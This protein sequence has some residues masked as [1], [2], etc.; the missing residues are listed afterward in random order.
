MAKPLYHHRRKLSN[1]PVAGGGGGN[2]LSFSSGK[3]SY[4]DVFSGGLKPRSGG[5]VGAPGFSSRRVAVE[6]YAEIFGGKN[7]AHHRGSS[8]PV[9]DLSELDDG[10]NG[11]DVFRGSGKKMDYSMI[12]GGGDDG[13]EPS[14][15]PVPAFDELFNGVKR[16]K[17]NEVKTR[18]P[19]ENGSPLKGPDRLNVSHNMKSHSCDGPAPVLDGEKQ[20]NMSF[21]KTGERR[22]DILNGTTHIAQL[23]AVPGFTYVIDETARLRDTQ[24][25]KSMPPIP[26]EGNHHRSSSDHLQ[27]NKK[28]KAM[29]PVKV[30]VDTK[31]P[32]PDQSDEKF[33]RRTKWQIPTTKSSEF[34]VKHKVECNRRDDDCLKDNLLHSDD[35]GLDSHLPKEPSPSCSSANL[36]DSKGQVKQSYVSS[37]GSKSEGSEAISGCAT[38]DEELDVNSAA[39]ASVEALRKA[40]E[41]AQESIRIAKEKMERKSRP[42]D[43]LKANGGCEINHAQETNG[44]KENNVKETGKSPEMKVKDP[45]RS[46]H[47]SE[48]GNSGFV[49]GFTQK[50]KPAA[51]RQA[52]SENVEV[53]GDNGVAT[54][55]SQ[56]LNNGKQK[57][58]ALASELVVKKNQ[59]LQPGDKD[60]DNCEDIKPAKESLKVNAMDEVNSV[61]S[62]RQ[63]VSTDAKL[64]VLQ[65]SE[66]NESMV[67][68]GSSPNVNDVRPGDSPMSAKNDEVTT[69]RQHGLDREECNELKTDSFWETFTDMQ[70][71]LPKAWKDLP[72]SN[73]LEVEEKSIE[74]KAGNK[75]EIISVGDNSDGKIGEVESNLQQEELRLGLDTKE[76]AADKENDESKLA[77]DI[78]S[79]GKRPE[80]D[81]KEHLDG[82]NEQE[83]D[84]QRL[85]KSVEHEESQIFSEE[86]ELQ[87]EIERIPAEL[88]KN[89]EA[90]S[91]DEDAYNSSLDKNTNVNEELEESVEKSRVHLFEQV[92]HEQ[93]SDT[94]FDKY[95]ANGIENLV[96]FEDSSRSFMENNCEQTSERT[97]TVEEKEDRDEFTA[98]FS[99]QESGEDE[100]VVDN[101]G[102][103]EYMYELDGDAESEKA[104]EEASCVE[105]EHKLET[106]SVDHIDSEE[107]IMESTVHD[108]SDAPASGSSGS[109]L[110]FDFEHVVRESELEDIGT[111]SFSYNGIDR[112][113]IDNQNATE[114]SAV[115]D[116]SNS[117]L[118]DLNQQSEIHEID[119]Q[120][121][122]HITENL[123]E[124]VR[125]VGGRDQIESDIESESSLHHGFV[126]ESGGTVETGHMA[127]IHSEKEVEKDNTEKCPKEQQWVQN[128]KESEGSHF[129]GEEDI[130]T[131]SDGKTDQ[132]S[133]NYEEDFSRTFVKETKE[134]REPFQKEEA[135][136]DDIGTSEAKKRDRERE[137]DR[138]AV[139]RAIREARERAFAEARERAERAA[140]EK[141]TAEVRQRAMAEARGKLDKVSSSVKAPVDKASIAAKLRAERAA[142]ERA[143]SEARERA[144]EK[145]MSQ[146]TTGETKPQSERDA[147]GK[148]SGA[149]RDAGLKHSYSSSDLDN[150]DGNSSESAQRRKARLERH[151]R[152]MERA[153]KALAEK[154]LRDVL[155]Q[156]EQAQKN[157][158][159]E[160]LDAEI[161]RWASGKEGNLRALLSTLQ[162]I[163]GPASGWQPISLT[164]IVTTAAVKKAY[165]KATLYV[166]PDKLQQR[167]ASIR[168]KYICEKVF[169]LLKAAWNKFNS[170]ER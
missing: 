71:E 42:R 139:E 11:S 125:E 121:F 45:I 4:D 48:L 13:D 31:S 94:I 24:Q 64:N 82:G 154:N 150:F 126:H 43:S 124:T 107:N 104:A 100:C 81:L 57:M 60:M 8:I 102:T 135:G 29:P 25:N 123:E 66:L 115:N 18:V 158:L 155:A 152:I 47:E 130:E 51:G 46:T 105:R 168:Q 149:S 44:D 63:G 169:D 95:S 170:E 103:N 76:G 91:M 96:D 146:K 40:I 114:A 166:H 72:E 27:S 83:S 118:N 38:S 20:F 21:H 156:R 110:M 97:E 7:G 75:V 85:A 88:H 6:D 116:S 14:A 138:M 99:R 33:G 34:S 134:T 77:T 142:V 32:A 119:D 36:K 50:E 160:T 22:K 122:T 109:T 12:F 117:D 101:V 78:E 132:S 52:V 16:A 79:D 136:K 159:A 3:D 164:E 140:V 141:A 165:R 53:S 162:Y 54:W 2:G 113:V 145:A 112:D 35:S 49:S 69:C 59:I 41:Q 89:E 151:Q 80:D 167:G 144:L 108:I 65:S 153:A 111:D 157:K 68:S 161:K 5:G 93:K 86:E 67:D 62:I 90:G 129:S 70:S 15:A 133:E 163:L 147:S 73:S 17:R 143:T 23:N 58:A 98:E 30:E 1:V 131:N 19:A 84:S 39:A 74:P 28:D 56:L 127:E 137:R 26:S 106:S 55:F 92:V 10:V 87:E 120:E 61:N 148:F 128:E 9:L 37:F